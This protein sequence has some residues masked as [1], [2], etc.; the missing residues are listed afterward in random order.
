[1]RRVSSTVDAGGPDIGLLVFV[2]EFAV[3]RIQCHL[4]LYSSRMSASEDNPFGLLLFLLLL[5]FAALAEQT[6]HESTFLVRS[7]SLR[8]R[9]RGGAVLSRFGGGSARFGMMAA[10]I[11]CWLRPE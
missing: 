9:L 3:R 10:G 11:P 1:M 4:C 8:R 6:T 5:F 7:S 2:L